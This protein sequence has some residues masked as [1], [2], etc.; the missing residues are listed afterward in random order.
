MCAAPVDRAPALAVDR[1]LPA[2]PARPRCALGT[3]ARIFVACCSVCSH[4]AAWAAAS[5]SGVDA[6]WLGACA[7]ACRSRARA[8]VFGAGILLCHS[9][10]QWA[11]QGRSVL[12]VSPASFPSE[13]AAPVTPASRRLPPSQSCSQGAQ[14]CL[15]SRTVCPLPAHV[16]RLLRPRSSPTYFAHNTSPSLRATDPRGC[17]PGA[18]SGRTLRARAM[19]GHS[20][21]GKRSEG[22]RSTSSARGRPGEASGSPFWRWARTSRCRPTPVHSN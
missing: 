17:A 13:L 10:R 15:G 5:D 7:S 1:S 22:M 16:T 2:R 3:P 9:G 12:V 18:S 6:A 14:P 20:Q 19:R 11:L 4:S 21:L 8:S